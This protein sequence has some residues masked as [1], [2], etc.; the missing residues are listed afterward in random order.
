MSF[1]GDAVAIAER[2]RVSRARPS[3]VKTFVCAL[4]LVLWILLMV[5][6]RLIAGF[7][8][9]PGAERLPMYFHRGVKRLFNLKCIHEGTLRTTR[10]TLYVANHVSYLDVFVLGSVLPGSFIAKSEVS[11]WPVF[12]KLAR[13]QNTLFFERNSRRAVDQI[14][15][16]KE[17]LGRPGNLIFFPEG[18]STEGTHVEPFR[19]TLFKS[20]EGEPPVWI[21]PVSVAYC[22]YAGE[23]M[24]QAERD[25]YAWYLPMTF[26]DHFLNGLG[27]RQATV[28]VILH[29]PVMLTQFDSRKACAQ[30]CESAVRRGIEAALRGET[31]IVRAP[32]A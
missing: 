16:M 17:E 21:Q 29:E 11:G 12:G 7:L 25:Y 18:T 22:D 30:Y 13:L 14:D 9:I 10:P 20:A 5:P 26:L 15:T 24:S 1:V 28:R 3:R 8:R 32:A 23:P 27:L 2:A 19:S 31:D 6:L 4:L